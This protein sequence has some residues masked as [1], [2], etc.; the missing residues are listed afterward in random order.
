MASLLSYL[1]GSVIVGIVG[2]VFHTNS[3][4]NVIDQK[5]EDFKESLKELI[6]SKFEAV[7]DRL[8]RIEKVLNGTMRHYD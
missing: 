6:D 4:V 5:H 2:W 7:G 3:K 8:E 1:M